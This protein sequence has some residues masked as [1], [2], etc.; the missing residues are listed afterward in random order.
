MSATSRPA[1]LQGFD[2]V[3]HLAALSNDPIGDLNERWTYDINLDATLG[4]ARAAKEAGVRRFVFASSCSMYGAPEETT[5]STKRA[6]PPADRLRR[7]EGAGGRGA[8][9]ARRPRVRRRLDAERDG[10][11]RVAATAARHRAQQPCRMGAYHRPHPPPLGRS[12]WRPLIHVR[13]LSSAA[14][15][16]LE[17]PDDL[18][19]GEAFN[20]GSAEQNYLS[21]TSRACSRK[22][23]AARSSSRPTPH[24]TRA[25]TASTSRARAGVSHARFR[26]G[27][28]PWSEELVD[29]YRALPLTTELFE[30]RHTFVCG[31]SATSSTAARWRRVCGGQLPRRCEGL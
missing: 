23:P 21:A 12:S 1:D 15:A 6:A 7:V 14:L 22:S 19:R 3:V 26:V 30:G 5:C 13:D 4:V 25:H 8:G 16:I 9:G 20:V 27:L 10:L 28:P 31:S 29:A 17:A 11:R 24:P 2:A 18:V